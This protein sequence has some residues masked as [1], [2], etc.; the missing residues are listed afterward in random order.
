M[1]P[2][3]APA[4]SSDTASTP[5]GQSEEAARPIA[6]IPLAHI[7]LQPRS[8]LVLA[9]TLYQTHLHGITGRTEDLLGN[10][11]GREK[12][13][14]ADLAGIRSTVAENASASN[15]ERSE[16]EDV[17]WEWTGHRGARTS[18]TFRRAKKVLKGG[19]FKM[20]PGGMMRG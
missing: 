18:L 13:V 4:S 11:E 20:G 12:V 8:L 19:A 3:S 5:A 14:N 7:L 17:E 15:P 1:I 16:E 10:G 9:D 6:A 2:S